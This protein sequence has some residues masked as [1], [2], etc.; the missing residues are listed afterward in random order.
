MRIMFLDLEVENHPYYGQVASPQHPDNYVVA[1]GFAV[2]DQ[3]YSGKIDYIYNT[4]E[5]T[6]ENTKDWLEIPDDVW[7]LVCHN[8]SFE[9]DWIWQHYP[10]KLISFLNRGGRVYCTQLGHYRLSGQRDL[11]PAL[12]EIAPE[13]GGTHKI[14]AVKLLWEQG[15]L[16]S[17]IDKDLLIEY[18]AGENGDV[19]NTRKVFYGQYEQ[20]QERGMWDIV[21]EQCGGLVY[22]A[23]CMSNGMHVDRKLAYENLERL[24]GKLN[25]LE[26]Q[27]TD[28]RA[29]YPEQIKELYSMGSLH[30]KSAWIFGGAMRVMGR[31]PAL[32]SEGKQKYIKQDAIQCA[33]TKEY[34]PTD[35]EIPNPVRYVSGKNKGKVKVFRIDSTEPQYKNGY[36]T[37]EAKGLVDLDD[38][39]QEFVDIFKR[40]H[41]TKLTQYD[42]SV[43]YSTSEDAITALVRQP[44]TNQQTRQLLEGVLQWAGINK[45]IGSFYLRH[46]YAKDG[47]V[48]DTSGALQYLTPDDKIHHRLNI[49]ATSTGRLSSSSP[50]YQNM[51]TDRESGVMT[52][53]TSRFGSDGV[54]L[55]ADYSN[56][57][58]IVL[59]DL[60]KDE[61]L[62]EIVRSGKSMHTINAA[63]IKGITYEE[64]DAILKDRTHELHDEYVAFREDCKP[65]EFAANYGAS[66]AGVAYAAGCTIEEAQE[67]LDM[68]AKSFPKVTEFVEAVTQEVEANT[69][70]HREQN[71]EGRW[72]LYSVGTYKAQGGLEY[73][74]RTHVTTKYDQGKPYEV[75]EF[76]P[77]QIRNYPI[78]GE[79]SLFVQVATGWLVRWLA[80]SSFFDGKAVVVNTVHDSV[81][82][83][84]HKDVLGEVV[85]GVKSILEHIPKGMRKF[86]YTLDLP[87]PVEITV[88]ENLQDQVTYEE[89]LRG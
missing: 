60:S 8:A 65:K 22:N 17:E 54:M 87:Y 56:L 53:Q 69:T 33:D 6:K 83:D 78:Q 89:F 70:S 73:S 58:V 59:A 9:L 74:F 18:L 40:E 26:K 4:K 29:D 34:Y 72:R 20:L 64:Y 61:N 46:N 11:Y 31:V 14:D 71:D 85:H 41:T 82:L 84:V 27:F 13:Y 35:A 7:L 16:T 51:P 81:W 67:F 66:A 38:Y 77:T 44:K 68:K 23:L 1:S 32:D 2:D 57:E 48:K 15:K 42:G 12:D 63:A 52:M 3:P 75:M 86:G 25:T 36:V 37:Y 19:A 5:D 45:T 80:R 30:H 79:A 50:N 49:C 28:S 88:G 43:V 39:P 76:R 55:Q 62:M 24:E 21:L 47:S 10:S